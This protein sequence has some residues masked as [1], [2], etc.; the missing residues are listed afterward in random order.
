VKLPPSEGKLSM[1]EDTD[2]SENP[3]QAVDGLL[4]LSPWLRMSVLSMVVSS[5]ALSWRICGTGVLGGEPLGRL[6][7]MG[8]GWRTVG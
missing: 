1:L 5:S 8:A 7:I 6:D 2:E 4:M 3:E